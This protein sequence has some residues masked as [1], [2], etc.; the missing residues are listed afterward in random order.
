MTAAKKKI[1]YLLTD[2]AYSDYSVQAAFATEEVAEEARQRAGGQIEEYTLY[3]TLPPRVT[4]YVI[5]Q[6]PGQPVKEYSVV[7]DPWETIYWEGKSTRGAAYNTWEIGRGTAERA[8]GT[9]KEAVRRR[10]QE[11]HQQREAEEAGLL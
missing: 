2:G 6:F 3:E 7:R 1:I 4:Y 10:W 5:E 11:K 9:N 8:W